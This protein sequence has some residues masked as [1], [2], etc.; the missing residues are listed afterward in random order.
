MK[1]QQV[2]FLLIQFLRNYKLQRWQLV[3]ALVFE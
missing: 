2:L 3:C 1:V